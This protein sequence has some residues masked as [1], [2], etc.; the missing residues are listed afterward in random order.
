MRH[1]P[2]LCQNKNVRKEKIKIYLLY[3]ICTQQQQFIVRCPLNKIMV[4]GKGG[5][6]KVIKDS[7]DQNL[8]FSS[9]YKFRFT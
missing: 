8:R 3:R 4:Q 7:Y 9:T 2:L 6:N 1:E 5:Y